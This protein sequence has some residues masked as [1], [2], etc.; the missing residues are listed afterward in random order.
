MLVWYNIP[1]NPILKIKAPK[2][3]A[4]EVPETLALV[5][6]SCRR[7]ARGSECQD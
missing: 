2:L 3:H 6:R 4:G 7:L 5:A 1:Q